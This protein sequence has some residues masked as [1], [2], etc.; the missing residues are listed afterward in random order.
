MFG[1]RRSCVPG[2]RTLGAPV[3]S[4]ISSVGRKARLFVPPLVRVDGRGD[5]SQFG[6]G[7]ELQHDADSTARGTALWSASAIN[8]Q[9]L[10]NR[11]RTGT[12]LAR[13]WERWEN[14]LRP[15]LEIE[16]PMIGARIKSRPAWSE[17]PPYARSWVQAGESWRIRGH[18]KEEFNFAQWYLSMMWNSRERARMEAVKQRGEQLS[19]AGIR[20][21]R[22]GPPEVPPL[23]WTAARSVGIQINK[24][25]QEDALRGLPKRTVPTFIKRH[26]TLAFEGTLTNI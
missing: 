10:A 7:R 23:Q 19:T 17:V 14:P 16:W 25:F 1:Q 2:C 6:E 4:E 24:A 11:W 15:V 20:W 13:M 5:L 9:V 8:P 26:L 22:G 21:K 12:P 18:T 3:F